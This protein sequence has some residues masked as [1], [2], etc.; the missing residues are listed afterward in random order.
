MSDSPVTTTIEEGVAAI[1]LDDGKANAVS[2]AVIDAVHAALDQATADAEAVC[3]IGRDGKF[4]A[5]FDLSVMTQGADATR[6]L[7]G[8]GGELLMRIYGH[9]Q[10]TVA[11]VTGHALAAGALLVLSCDTR[12][13]ADV[14]AKI[15]L[16]ETAIGMGLPRYAVELARDRL[17][18][19]HFTR[20]T[21]QAEI[22]SPVTAVDAGYLDQVVTL[23]ELED[24][25][26]GAARRLGQFSTS[27]YGLTKSQG[28]RAI[29]DEVL[30]GLGA[31][32]ELMVP[33]TV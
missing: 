33:P 9:P 26:I 20:A 3:I 2:H 14:P 22:Y 6:G 11:A 21:V 30:A 29:I 15:G 19:R 25:A 8:A 5:G 13:G 17:S 12:I 7:V 32:M 31:D 1:R 24:A 4:S 16:N 27:A 10:P 18:K 23:D 28:R